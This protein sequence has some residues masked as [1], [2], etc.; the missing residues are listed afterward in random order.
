MSRDVYQ[1]VTDAILRAL[2][3]EIVPWRRPWQHQGGQRNLQ[4]GRPYRGVNQWLTELQAQGRGYESPFWTTFRAAKKAGGRVRKGEK[5]TLVVFWKMLK[6]EREC[7]E[8]AKTI[9][10]LRHY[11]VFN[12]A[13]CEGLE[14]PPV[15][16]RV[17]VDP[18]AA[19]ER[20][21]A[22]MPAAPEIR[23]GGD[24]AFYVP[25]LDVVQLPARDDFRS[26]DAYYHTAFHELAHSTGH[27][28]RL[29]REGIMGTHRFGSCDY[30]R[31]ELIA[32]LGAS[33]VAGAAGID[34]DIPQSAAYLDG[35]R[36]AI[37]GDKR[38]IVTAAGRA[39]RAA[40]WIL[41]DS[42]EWGRAAHD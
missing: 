3:E 17:T 24:R 42:P 15:P 28:S 35:W 5:G 36:R 13:Q 27:A 30:S 12:A 2:D 9:P 23:H 39:Q 40:D 32:E 4:S 10:M 33:M 18:I 16:E 22:E 34:P 31:E 37:S 11:T 25:A 38:L 26:A 1:E 20:V 7:E 29:G 19:G 21:L 8:E 6:V 14:I 41:G